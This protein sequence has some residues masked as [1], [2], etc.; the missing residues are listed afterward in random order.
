MTRTPF[1]AL[2]LS[3]PAQAPTDLSSGT[4]AFESQPLDDIFRMLDP[5]EADLSRFESQKGIVLLFGEGNT[6]LSFIAART[7]LEEAEVELKARD[8]I[9]LIDSNP[10]AQGALRRELGV[11]GKAVVV[12]NTIGKIVLNSE[13][14]VPTEALLAALDS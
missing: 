3:Q 6:D 4:A 12:V 7:Q 13:E 5:A 1:P 14:T 8:V 11:E 9:V 2:A 10:S